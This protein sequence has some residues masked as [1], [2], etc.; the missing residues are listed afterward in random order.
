[1][2]LTTSCG[3]GG[4]GGGT[5]RC[6]GRAKVGHVGSPAQPA[7]EG[8]QGTRQGAAR[9]GGAA[10]AAV[11]VGGAKAWQGC[12][13]VATLT[14]LQSGF[15][16]SK[17]WLTLT[18]LSGALPAT[19]FF[20]RWNS[21]CV[22]LLGSSSRRMR[23]QSYPKLRARGGG[24]GK[25]RGHLFVPARCRRCPAPLPLIASFKVAGSLGSQRVAAPRLV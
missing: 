9:E 5:R 18:R 8:Q 13:A 22:V 20:L 24:A 19:R 1:M 25:V 7:A 12:R 3:G 14:D 17:P 21:C 2:T 6:V 11:S 15:G 10:L 23:T 4:P 16:A